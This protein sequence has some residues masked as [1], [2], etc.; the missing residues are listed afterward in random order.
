MNRP[1]PKTTEMIVVIGDVHHLVWLAVEGLERMEAEYGRRIDQV[2]SVGDFGLFLQP[3]DWNFLTGPKKY[4]RPEDCPQIRA[5]WERWR[6]PISII[7][8]NHEPFHKLRNW[9]ATRFGGRLGYT[10]AGWVPHD[11]RGLRVAGLSGIFQPDELKFTNDIERRQRGMPKPTNWPEMVAECERGR[12]SPRRLTYFKETELES[13]RSLAPAP[14][15][16]LTHDWPVAHGGINVVSDRRPEREILDALTPQ[17]HCC[18]H[19]HRSKHFTVAS[20]EVFA[21]NIIG[22]GHQ[23]NPGWSVAFSWDSETLIPLGVW[24]EGPV[25]G[26]DEG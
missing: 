7:A 16:L 1:S 13:A 3:E 14:H 17:F 5:A 11:V 21:L 26:G 4:R 24:P 23:I 10:N 15:L 6:W 18:G 19:H 9:N 12:I 2:F 22:S 8:G 25:G 20:T